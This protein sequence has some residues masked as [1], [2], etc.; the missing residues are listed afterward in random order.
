MAPLLPQEKANRGCP[1]EMKARGSPGAKLLPSRA[2]RAR[3][4]R[5]KQP[6]CS[7]GLFSLSA[8]LGSQRLWAAAAPLR[9]CPGA[10]GLRHSRCSVRP[11]ALRGSRCSLSQPRKEKIPCLPGPKKLFSHTENH[12]AQRERRKPEQRG[13]KTPAQR[14]RSRSRP[15]P[16]HGPSRL[17]A[18]KDTITILWAQSGGAWNVPS[19]ELTPRQLQIQ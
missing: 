8:R 15:G 14:T 13:F 17:P 3:S 12:G 1:E 19:Q 4:R 10:P 6:R 9:S 16:A 11:Q 2:P 18:V 5:V 7:L